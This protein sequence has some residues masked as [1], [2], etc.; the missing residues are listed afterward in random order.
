MNSTTA[1]HPSSTLDKPTQL[2]NVRYGL[3]NH[4]I[5]KNSQQKSDLFNSR[6]LSGSSQSLSC[7]SIHPHRLIASLM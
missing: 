4:S 3:S 6:K 2:S 1:F 5:P 7:F